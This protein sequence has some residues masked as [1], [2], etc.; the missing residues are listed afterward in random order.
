MTPI[1]KTAQTTLDHLAALARAAGG[2]TRLDNRPGTYMP[3]C[4]EW[5]AADQLSLAH[6]GE[7][8]G[9]AMRD[10]D[11]V[12]W[13][14]PDRRWYPVSYRND[15]TGTDR[16]AVEFG[17]D[18][19]PRRYWPREQRSQATFAATWLRNIRAQQGV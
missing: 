1:S 12:F 5:I 18:G 9:D 19:R 14:A 13:L 16:P 3:L 7:S 6:Y 4:V 15:W 11:M 10:P 17:D 2:A 8:N